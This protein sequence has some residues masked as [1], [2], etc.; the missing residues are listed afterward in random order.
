MEYYR[1]LFDRIVRDCSRATLSFPEDLY[2][3]IPDKVLLLDIG[4]NILFHRGQLFPYNGP[5]T[6]REFLPVPYIIV[7]YT[8][9]P[10]SDAP[11]IS[12][13][14]F[15]FSGWGE[16]LKQAYSDLY[17]NSEALSYLPKVRGKLRIMQKVL[18]LCALQEIHNAY[19]DKSLV[20]IFGWLYD[21]VEQK[22]EDLYTDLLLT[23]DE[24]LLPLMV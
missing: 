2:P 20:N 4:N 1:N 23:H 15:T 21:P 24:T 16:S 11:L 12:P 18:E 10:H 6:I 14:H 3:M 8:W 5:D 19:Q 7:T 22:P 9:S 13:L 17:F